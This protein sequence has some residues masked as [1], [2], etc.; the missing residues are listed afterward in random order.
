M[1]KTEG[2]HLLALYHPQQGVVLAQMN[3]QKKGREMT[4]APTLLKQID[5]RGVPKKWGAVNPLYSEAVAL[6][7]PPRSKRSRR[8][9]P[10]RWRA[11]D[12]WSHLT[13][14]EPTSGPIAE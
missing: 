7:N 9:A 1:G 5:L 8:R 13:R 12:R 11:T 14:L 3:V 2:V 10:R 6:T 4:F